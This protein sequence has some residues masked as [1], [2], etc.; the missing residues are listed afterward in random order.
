MERLH[1]DIGAYLNY[2]FYSLTQPKDYKDTTY[3]GEVEEVAGSMEEFEQ[4]IEYD[5]LDIIKKHVVAKEEKK[6][7]LIILE[8]QLV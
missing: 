3:L 6:V 8:T 1:L 2:L 7:A 4:W 5:P